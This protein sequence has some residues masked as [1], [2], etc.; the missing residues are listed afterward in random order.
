ME[1]GKKEKRKKEKKLSKDTS[2]LPGPP[3]AVLPLEPAY[4]TT[5]R[6]ECLG[7]LDVSKNQST[8]FPTPS[9]PWVPPE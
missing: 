8:L 1:K 7:F 3:T 2:Y 5:A 6:Q 4:P 9:H